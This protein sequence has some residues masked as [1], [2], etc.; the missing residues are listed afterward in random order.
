[1][2][3][4]SHNCLVEGANAATRKIQRFEHLNHEEMVKALKQTREKD[5]DNGILVIT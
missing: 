4:L 2:D 1:M 3:Q 5:P